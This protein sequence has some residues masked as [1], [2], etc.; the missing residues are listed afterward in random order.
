[1]KGFDDGD[2]GGDDDGMHEY[3][4]PLRTKICIGA[5]QWIPQRGSVP[6]A[7]PLGRTK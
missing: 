2:G 4:G 5:M 3:I 7:M 1:M 6:L